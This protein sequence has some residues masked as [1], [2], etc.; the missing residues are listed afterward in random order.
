MRAPIPFL[1]ISGGLLLTTPTTTSL[2]A[3]S[4]DSGSQVWNFDIPAAPA[5]EN[6]PQTKKRKISEAEP[7][8]APVEEVKV[9]ATPVAAAAETEAPA[10]TT[11]QTAKVEKPKK[12]GW[13]DDVDRQISTI[14]SCDA[15][16]GTGYVA[17]GMT[18]KSFLVLAV[19]SGQTEPELIYKT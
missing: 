1:Q 19:K 16:D 12:K 10:T 18:D 17:I 4:L 7:K 9:E 13:R 15:E 2:T 14:S 11:A 3:F 8:D 5:P 6:Q